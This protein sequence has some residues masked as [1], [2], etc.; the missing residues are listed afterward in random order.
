MFVDKDNAPAYLHLTS[1]ILII[2]I[3]ILFIEAKNK[4]NNPTDEKEIN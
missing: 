3:I 1:G 2:K 4:T